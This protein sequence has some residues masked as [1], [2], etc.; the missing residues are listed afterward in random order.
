MIPVRTVPPYVRSVD[1]DDADTVIPDEPARND[2]DHSPKL[3]PIHIPGFRRTSQP[4]HRFDHLRSKSPPIISTPVLE[5][6]TR[7]K[8]FA[9]PE[10]GG[11]SRRRIT[12]AEAEAARD[13]LA[14]YDRQREAD[15]DE[16]ALK[17]GSR[18]ARKRSLIYKYKVPFPPCLHQPLARQRD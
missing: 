7:W 12:E 5:H 8:S 9:S 1:W 17:E 11:P 18:E 10:T 14:Y 13:I 4:G 16:S 2:S 3:L 15:E 6:G